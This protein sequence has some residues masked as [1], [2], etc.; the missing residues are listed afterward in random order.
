MTDRLEAWLEGVHAGTF[1][2]D[3]DKPVTF[4]YDEDAP[5]TPISLSLPRDRPAARNAATNFLENLLPD[6]D[7]TRQRMATAYGAPSSRTFDL[8]LSAGEDIAGGLVLTPSG[9]APGAN[10]GVLNPADDEDVASRIAAIKRD[11]DDW[12]PRDAPARF[13]LAGTQGKFAL[14]E[15]DG[16]WYWSNAGVPSTHIVKPARTDLRDLEA[17]ETAALALA[18]KAGISASAAAVGTFIDQTAFVTERFDRAR[19]GDVLRRLHAED[20]AQS[21]GEG[22]ERKY[23]VQPRVIARLLGG[24]DDSGQ[25]L[26]D[27]LHQLAFNVL[28]G[29]AD[30]HAKNYSVMLRPG[31]VSLSPLY[32]A[33]PVGLYPTF[34]QKLAMRI[35]GARHAQAAHPSLWRKLARTLDFDGDEMV[36][37][38]VSVAEGVA[39]HNDSAWDTLDEAQAGSLRQMIGRN[40]DVAL[41]KR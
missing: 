15:I 6:H 28:I 24:A 7:R 20:L 16:D 35:G 41:G 37:I 40:V 31:S 10:P 21:L 32:D 39:R 36:A 5:A 8:L 38:V 13:S 27:F 25:L 9:E 4:A 3:H 14:A 22:P 12:V 11:S 34:D 33:V 1:E 17:A 19:E 29:N 26:R 30:A 18:R 2:F 23:E